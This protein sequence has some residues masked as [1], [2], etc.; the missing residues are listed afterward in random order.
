MGESSLNVISLFT[1]V[2]MRENLN[3]MSGHFKKIL[4]LLHDVLNPSNYSF[5]GQP[6]NRVSFSCDLM[7]GVE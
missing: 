2:M 5:S 1:I 6:Y 3:L 7:A 4:D